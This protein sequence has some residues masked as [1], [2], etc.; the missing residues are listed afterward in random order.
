MRVTLGVSSFVSLFCV[1]SRSTSNPVENSS[2]LPFFN[3]N[4]CFLHSV[5]IPPHCTLHPHAPGNLFLTSCS[6]SSSPNIFSF[7][8]IALFVILIP[9]S[10]SFSSKLFFRLLLFLLLLF[11]PQ[12]P[13]CFFYLLLFR[14]QL[15]LFLLRL[16]FILFRP[17]STL[18]LLLLY[19]P[20]SLL[21][22]TASLFPFKVVRNSFMA[23][24][25][26]VLMHM[27][28]C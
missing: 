3:C 27:R 13:A 5:A 22:F 19:L 20:L 17:F 25:N 2:C 11:L 6:L 28:K 9:S 15:V 1:N 14:L 12:P 23:R 26:W 24:A 16:F 10:C 7:R 4:Y 18:S 8:S 21:P